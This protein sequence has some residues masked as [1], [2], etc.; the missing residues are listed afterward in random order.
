MAEAAAIA[1]ALRIAGGCEEVGM[2]TVGRWIV[3]CWR[4]IA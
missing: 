4:G 2:S 1:A 3:Y